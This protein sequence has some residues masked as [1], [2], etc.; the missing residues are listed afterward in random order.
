MKGNPEIGTL[1]RRIQ[2][3]GTEPQR[4]QRRKKKE[5][6]GMSLLRP[7][8]FNDMGSAVFVLIVERAF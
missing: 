8:K 4:T 5:K 3:R 7:L 2:H 1:E 6:E